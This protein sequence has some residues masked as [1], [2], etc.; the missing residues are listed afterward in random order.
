V[1]TMKVLLRRGYA[2]SRWRSYRATLAKVP[3]MVYLLTFKELMPHFVYRWSTLL[4]NKLDRGLGPRT[5]ILV[6]FCEQPPNRE[7]RAYLSP[8]RDRLNV[9]TLV[10]DWKIGPEVERSVTRFLGLLGRHLEQRRIGVLTQDVAEFGE[11]SFS[12]AS[13]HMGTTRMSNDP[14]SGVVDNNCRVHSVGNLFIAGSSVFPSAGHANPTLT[15][16]A[17]ALRLSVHLRACLQK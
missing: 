7:S 1:Q 6:N 10:L 16:V 3:E 13:H 8:R 2:G 5:F 12:D 14:R 15:I 17:L 11:L 9:N 4:R